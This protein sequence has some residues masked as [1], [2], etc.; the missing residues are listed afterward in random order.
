MYG[1]PMLKLRESPFPRHLNKQ[2]E[3]QLCFQNKCEK[4]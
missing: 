4:L 1:C 2:G 3:L